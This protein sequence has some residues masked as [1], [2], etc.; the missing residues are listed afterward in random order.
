MSSK[1]QQRRLPECFVCL[2]FTLLWSIMF[3][4]YC[5]SISSLLLP[6]LLTSCI[7]VTSKVNEMHDTI[8]PSINLR[9]D[10]TVFQI[11][12]LEIAEIDGFGNKVM[13]KN[14]TLSLEHPQTRS[15]AS[16]SFWYFYS[17]G[18][19]ATLN[20]SATLYPNHKSKENIKGVKKKRKDRSLHLFSF[21][22]L[23]LSSLSSSL[24]SHLPPA[25]RIDLRRYENG[26]I[27]EFAK[28]NISL[29]PNSLKLSL[30]IANWNF[31]NIK[32]SIQITTKAT[33]SNVT[34]QNETAPQWITVH[35]GGYVSLWCCFC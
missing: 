14:Y 22:S 18:N 3:T 35:S 20:I 23:C 25:I 33:S 6:S 19:G 34:C 12:I 4:R 9:A 7:S 15:D 10:D 27:M 30:S 11:D 24:L 32:N 5:L 17:F 13:Q 29:A 1:L 8:K 2:H 31:A 16:H 28:Q 21:V 26:T